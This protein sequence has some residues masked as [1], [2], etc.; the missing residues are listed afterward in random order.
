M[1]QAVFRKSSRAKDSSAFKL[2]IL[3]RT[4][5]KRLLELFSEGKLFG[6]VHTC[7]GQEFTGI[8]I[9]HALQEGDQ[10][11]SNHRCHGHFLATTSDLVGLFSEIM[12]KSRGVC[13][14]RG[15]SQHLCAK[16]FFSNGIQGGIAPVSAGLAFYQKLAD[17]GHI[18]VLFI[19]DGTLG[20]GAIYETLNIASKWELPL[21]IV[22]EDNQVAQSTPQVQTLAGN[23]CARASAFG[24]KTR[25]TSTWET[26]DLFTAASDCVKYV[27][28]RSK[29]AFLKIDTFRLM[30]H[31][32]GD[33]DRDP[34]IV[35]SYWD[36]DPIV[37]F[38]KEFPQ[39][40]G[41]IQTEATAAVE[42]AV[43]AA[44]QAPYPEIDTITEKSAV[45]SVPK[46]SKT[47]IKKQG[48]VVDRIR[49]AL[50]ENMD[51]DERIIIIG[52]DIEA[53]YGGAFKVTDGLSETFPGRV[54]NTPI[55]EAAI[56]GLGAGLSINGMFPVCEIMFGD[57]LTLA[58][59][60]IINHLSKFR[61][62]YGDQFHVPMIIRTPMGGKR[63]YGPTHS[64]SLEKHFL[65]IPHIEMLAIHSRYDPSL[66]YNTLFREANSPTLVI[67]NKL[68]Y[69]KLVT[70]EVPDGFVLQQSN[71]RFPTTRITPEA[72]PDVTIVGYG[73]ML[74]DIEIAV[75]HAFEKE[76]IICEVIC[77]IQLYPLNP[78]P[79]IESLKRS[80]RLL[81]V[82]EGQNFAALGAEII[83]QVM[84]N[85]PS[86]LR[87]VRRIG[88]P[89]HP[90]P[91]SGP[92]EKLILPNPD[93]IETA[94]AELFESA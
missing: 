69:S 72:E 93:S 73:G 80:G 76:E 6:T 16:G 35:N 29:P 19:G 20:E 14:G 26:D 5:E 62:M 77:P 56:T 27:R 71:E 40:A 46:W 36:K 90:I 43:K 82:E 68:L 70:D 66:I 91:S 17:S 28:A 25:E 33:D 59:D 74:P 2:A 44:D 60:Q 10:V 42:S 78:W 58:A 24:I 45:S 88:P 63:G 3:I 15:G 13:G 11:F 85:S 9:A 53:P 84:E 41:A 51:R 30:A 61:Y 55:S 83:S 65:G 50:Y 7:I 39:E 34:S 4:A 21:L 37:K 64:Q 22:L 92:L 23:I 47:Q 86:S 94:I 87:H 75:W 31:S 81:I 79:I 1:S 57:F 52:E 18:V 67:E 38:T 12:G 48:R 8:A 49:N 89:Q 32:K 54:R